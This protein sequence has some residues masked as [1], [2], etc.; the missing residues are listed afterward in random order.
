M[1]HV[2]CPWSFRVK[3]HHL[4]HYCGRCIDSSSRIYHT[5]WT[6]NLVHHFSHSC[7][8]RAFGI[9]GFHAFLFNR[10]WTVLNA[11]SRRFLSHRGA[12]T[13]RRLS[14]FVTF[15]LHKS[16]LVS[17]GSNRA[18]W[19]WLVSAAEVWLFAEDWLSHRSCST[20]LVLVDIGFIR[21]HDFD[22]SSSVLVEASYSGLSRWWIF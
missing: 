2:H 20:R 15:T 9:R 22:R 8:M 18:S 5:Q 19:M 10:Q 7:E 14:P 21:L 17:L 13:I 4:S 1:R 3:A 12:T 11:G 16:V 6:N